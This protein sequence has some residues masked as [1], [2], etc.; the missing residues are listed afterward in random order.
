MLTCDLDVHAGLVVPCHVLG[1]HCDLVNTWI[2]VA[3]LNGL[4]CHC[5]V[6]VDSPNSVAEVHLILGATCVALLG[7]DKNFQIQ[8]E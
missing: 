2:F 3:M 8:T 5:Q 6:L 7:T 4:I 1:L